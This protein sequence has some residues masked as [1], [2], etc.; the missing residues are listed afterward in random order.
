[1][2]EITVHGGTECAALAAAAR[3]Q[4]DITVGVVVVH[5]PPTLE[6]KRIVRRVTIEYEDV[7][8]PHEKT[9]PFGGA[10]EPP[11]RLA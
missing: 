1:M 3:Q 6:H 4:L 8:I 10:P 11:D 5:A 9:P 2:P 7:F